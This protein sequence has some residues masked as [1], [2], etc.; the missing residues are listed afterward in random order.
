MSLL[1]KK[2]YQRDTTQV[3]QELLGKKLIHF[4]NGKI[5]SGVI[6]ETEAYLGITDPACHTYNGRRT[7]RVQS[8]YLSGGHAYV[9]FIYGMHFC[10][11]VVTRNEKHPE[12][13]LI[14]A[15]FPLDGLDLMKKRRHTEIQKN[16]CSGPAKLCEALDIDKSCDGLS[17]EG[18][19]IWIEKGVP[20]SK[21]KDHIKASPRIGIPYAKE[22]IQ[23]PLR[24]TIG[25]AEIV[26]LLNSKR[27]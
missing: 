2:F 26:P 7:E 18:P 19:E 24:F 14:R 21:I 22:A 15:L 4:V 25:P 12:A 27:S 5:T 20:F 6:I 9:Y 13:V 10:F 23:W 3:A 16:L 8:M 11:N 17:L 1:P